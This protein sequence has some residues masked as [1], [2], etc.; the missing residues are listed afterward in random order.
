MVE[1]NEAA[2]VVVTVK[3][4]PVD[5]T[6]VVDVAAEMVPSGRRLQLIDLCG[7]QHAVSRTCVYD[8]LRE[9]SDHLKIITLRHEIQRLA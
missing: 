9:P 3:A 5:E 4:V 8:L 7:H 6:A 2:I 1:E